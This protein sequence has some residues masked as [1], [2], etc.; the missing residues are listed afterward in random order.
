[1]TKRV[2]ITGCSEGGIG[3]HCAERLHNLGYIVVATVRSNVDK[4]SLIKLGIKSCIMDMNSKESI[5]SGFQEAIDLLDG[6]IDVLIQNAGYGALGCIEDVPVE[7]MEQQF[8]TN[9]FGLHHLNTLVLPLMRQQG[10]G[11]VIHHG[12]VLGLVAMPFR[13]AYAASKHATEAYSQTLRIEL[14]GTGIQVS[15][16]NTGPVKSCFRLNAYQ[17][18]LA[19]IDYKNGPNKERYKGLLTRLANQTVEPAMTLPPEAVFKAVNHAIT[20]KKAKVRYLITTPS[21]VMSLAKRVLPVRMLDVLL[22]RAGESEIR[23]KT[24]N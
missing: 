19:T 22:R 13:G 21:K 12:S 24:F 16:L 1:M 8:S 11:R 4:E 7:V 20:S 10:E 2:L 5:N 9:L 23:P 15:M 6:Q 17:N 14:Y 18:F 3:R